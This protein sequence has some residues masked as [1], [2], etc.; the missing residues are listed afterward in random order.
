[1]VECFSTHL[2]HQLIGVRLPHAAHELAVTLIASGGRR[3]RRAARRRRPKPV[4]H[5]LQLGAA[6]AVHGVV[7]VERAALRQAGQLVGSGQEAAG[8]KEAAVAGVARRD[9]RV[10]G[11]VAQNVEDRVQLVGVGGARRL[12]RRF[13]GVLPAAAVRR[14][15][16]LAGG[17]GG[18]GGG[19][20]RRN[21]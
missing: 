16:G 4:H 14:D 21:R 7:Q 1:M 10:L 2:S 12:G 18:G 13:A 15:D 3:R 5:V 20:R 17:G 11:V 9:R 19:G 6:R 8:A